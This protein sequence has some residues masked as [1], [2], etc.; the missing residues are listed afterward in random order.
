MTASIASGGSEISGWDSHPLENTLDEVAQVLGVSKE[1]LRQIEVQA[2]V[3]C[4][5]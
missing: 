3:K 2:L 4:C 1:R 5:R